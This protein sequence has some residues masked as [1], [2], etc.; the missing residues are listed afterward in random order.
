MDERLIEF[1]I[2]FENKNSLEIPVMLIERKKKKKKKWFFKRDS[3]RI[4]VNNFI[5][6]AGYVQCDF[7]DVTIVIAVNTE[8]RFDTRDPISVLYFSSVGR[9]ES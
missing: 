7:G 3:S 1:S 5:L 2:L 4:V 9:R 6:I 8:S